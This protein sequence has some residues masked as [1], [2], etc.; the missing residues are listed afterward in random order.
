MT[1]L[2]AG[3]VPCRQLAGMPRLS[4]NRSQSPEC[5]L[6]AFQIAEKMGC[7]PLPGAR[8]YR[9]G[10][11]RAVLDECPKNTARTA[12]TSGIEPQPIVWLCFLQIRTARILPGNLCR[13][14]SAEIALGQS[15]GQLF[16][17][18]PKPSRNKIYSVELIPLAGGRPVGRQTPK[19]CSTRSLAFMGVALKR[20]PR[21]AAAGCALA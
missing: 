19:G 20:Q 13:R 15:S 10:R 5:V 3:R 18:K 2:T 4:E 17:V 16:G 6:L 12:R 7:G 21:F 8:V 11:G 14:S 9:H 1:P